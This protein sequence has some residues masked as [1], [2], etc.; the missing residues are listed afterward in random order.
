VSAG[1]LRRI[2]KERKR[3][4]SGIERLKLLKGEIDRLIKDAQ[5]RLGLPPDK[6]PKQILR[7]LRGFHRIKRHECYYVGR[8]DPLNHTDLYE[9]YKEVVERW[10][11]KDVHEWINELRRIWKLTKEKAIAKIVADDA[12]AYILLYEYC[13]GIPNSFETFIDEK[14]RLLSIPKS[15]ILRTSSGGENGLSR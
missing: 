12:Y 14:K 3:I 13:M 5:I 11:V 1:E 2:I 15:M 10:T 7:I 4:E 8:R 9:M 6:T